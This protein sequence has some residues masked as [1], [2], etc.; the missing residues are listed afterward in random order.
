MA[1]N[2]WRGEEAAR[3]RHTGCK[4]GGER[5]GPGLKE[6]AEDVTGPETEP[7]I[8]VDELEK[9]NV[10]FPD[11]TVDPPEMNRQPTNIR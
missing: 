11:S 6:V 4:I 5:E 1:S 2:S 3:V 10:S 8:Q 9:N 7:K